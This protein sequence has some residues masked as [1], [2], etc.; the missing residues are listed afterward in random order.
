MKEERVVRYIQISGAALFYA[1]VGAVMAFLINGIRNGWQ[2]RIASSEYEMSFS[3]SVII[4][5][6]IFIVF[7]VLTYVVSLL[8]WGI[9]KDKPRVK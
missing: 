1:F 3:F 9:L 8:F 6:V 5:A 7:S 4:S 2:Y